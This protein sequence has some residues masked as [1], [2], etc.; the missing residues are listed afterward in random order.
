MK[1]ETFIAKSLIIGAAL[2]L[3]TLDARAQEKCGEFTLSDGVKR[4]MAVDQISVS[5]NEL[6][7]GAAISAAKKEKRKLQLQLAATSPN[8]NR[9]RALSARKKKV[10]RLVKSS[11]EE[12]LSLPTGAILAKGRIQEEIK[13]IQSSL[14]KELSKALGTTLRPRK[15]VSDLDLNGTA[16]LDLDIKRSDL[17]SLYSRVTSRDVDRG[18]P[19]ANVEVSIRSQENYLGEV[20]LVPCARISEDPNDPN[21][22]QMWGIRYEQYDR[23]VNAMAAWNITKGSPEVTVVVM[24]TGVDHQHPDLKD[25]FSPKRGE[26]PDNGADDD[27]NGL[28]DDVLGYDFVNSDGDPMDDN[29]H[30]THCAGTSAATGNNGIGIIGI[31]PEAS[32]RAY[33]V[34][35][36]TG[37]GSF[38]DVVAAVKDIRKLKRVTGKPV[39]VNMSFGAPASYPPMEQEVAEASREGVIFVA[40]AGN[41]ASTL[42]HYPASYPSI[43]AVGAS[44]QSGGVAPFSNKGKEWV[45][46]A[47]PGV[48]ILSTFPSGGYRFLQ[49][50][51]MAAPH[52][53][54][55]VALML[56]RNPNLS[57]AEALRIISDP[58][59]S[60]PFPDWEELAASEGV[61]DAVKAIAAAG[62]GNQEPTPTPTPIAT[63]TFTPTFTPIGTP[64]P[65]RTPTRTATLTPTRTPSRTPTRTPTS[66]P[67]CA[68]IGFSTHPQS[69]TVA[70]GTEVTFTF[71][72]FGPV[73]ERNWF[74]NGFHDQGSVNSNVFTVRDAPCMFNQAPVVAKIKDACGREVTSNTAILT[75][76]GCGIGGNPTATPTRTPSST[77][78]RTPTVTPTRSAQATSTPT[79][80][81]TRTPTPGGPTATPTAT[82]TQGSSCNLDLLL[83]SETQSVGRGGQQVRVDALGYFTPFNPSELR[84]S[85]KWADDNSLIMENQE[86]RFDFIPFSGQA[87]SRRA[88]IHAERRCSNGQIAQGR[89]PNGLIEVRSDSQCI[90][91]SIRN[92]TTS[93][94]VNEGE[95]AL[96]TVKASG[97]NAFEAYEVMNGVTTR[98]DNNDKPYIWIQGTRERNGAQYFF[99][100]KGVK[101]GAT[102]PIV[103]SQRAILTVR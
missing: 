72:E 5:V 30:G 17:S 54:G 95:F 52:V 6:Q 36:H 67:S 47:A 82:P 38:V 99:K 31:A 4:L 56:S 34:L 102:C 71:S 58:A 45:D 73:R 35:G 18:A 62:G 69:R 88:Y 61:V 11:R 66:T 50:T 80:T 16:L 77:P 24:D 93:R 97:A 63:A 41:E 90:A 65:T 25:R 53:A 32:I 91:P 64:T 46:V 21:I 3:C 49:G 96:F 89:T 74:I 92:W 98:L 7:S 43:I 19:I 8:S 103:E 81:P 76:T 70:A 75:L 37:S 42:P 68:A 84:Y 9:F 13:K 22:N 20:Q 83:T 57:A 85:L 1:V 100:M 55:V 51:S 10:D 26:V 101:S 23:G 27:G 39:V 48:Q 94:T 33:K 40:A 87:G 15:I 79:R 14:S 86:G 28:V 29:F 2:L 44:T 60:N 78:T 59:N 12:L